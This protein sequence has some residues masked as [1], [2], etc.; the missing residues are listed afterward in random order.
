MGLNPSVANKALSKTVRD[1]N[2]CSVNMQSKVSINDASR[3]SVNSQNI[4]NHSEQKCVCS[5]SNSRTNVV[6]KSEKNNVNIT[7]QD[8]NNFVYA[9][10]FAVLCVDS[11]EDEGDSLEFDTVNNLDTFCTVKGCQGGE[12]VRIHSNLGKIP[13]SFAPN[14]PPNVSECPSVFYLSNKNP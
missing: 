1:Y 2:K 4:V 9:N 14:S 12:S 6:L 3:R 10:R 5:D 11:S 7:K 13:S 8:C